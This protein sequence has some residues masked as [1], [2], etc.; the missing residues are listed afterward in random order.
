MQRGTSEAVNAA[1]EEA[2]A[3]EGRGAARELREVAGGEGG[4]DGGEAEAGILG[5]E[6]G[7]AFVGLHL[8]A[9]TE[10]ID[11]LE[12]AIVRDSNLAHPHP[13]HNTHPHTLRARTRIH[14]S[15]LAGTER[16]RTHATQTH[17]QPARIR[18]ASR[19]HAER[20]GAHR[21]REQP[22]ARQSVGLGGRSRRVDGL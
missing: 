3:S 13:P 16:T 21:Q 15:Y 14:Q 9:A 18:A 17:I 5:S 20:A 1:A 10:Q 4:G 8:D 19:G 22:P 2:W 6:E 11:L 12:A 7:N